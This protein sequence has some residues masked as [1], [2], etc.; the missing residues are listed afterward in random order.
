LST[1]FEIAR[2]QLEG[3]GDIAPGLLPRDI[4]NSWRRSLQAGLDPLGPPVDA[5]VSPSELRERRQRSERITRFARPELELLY[6]QI[7]GAN[8]MVAFAD[9]DGV[10]LDTISDSD[11]QSTSTGRTIV[12]GSV[13]K[14]DLRGTN[15]LGLCLA[16]RAPAKVI[17]QEH[18]FSEHGRVSCLAAPIFDSRNRIVGLIDASSDITARQHHTLALVKLAATN[19]ENRLFLE[20]HRNSITLVF[21]PREEYLTTMSVGMLAFDLDGNL[22]GS[23]SQAISMLNGISLG[24]NCLFQDIFRNSFSDIIDRLFRGRVVQL[25][26]WLGSTVF[27]AASFSSQSDVV[28][29]ERRRSLGISLGNG[30][31]RAVAAE[32]PKR[33]GLVM[34]DPLLR[35]QIT[36]ACNAAKVGLP[37]VIEGKS[38][39]GKKAAAHEIHIRTHPEAPLFSVD[40]AAIS[41]SYFESLLSLSPRAQ[42]TPDDRQISQEFFQDF[43]TL[44]GTLHF[45]EIVELPRD[46]QKLLVRFLDMLGEGSPDSNRAGTK[47]VLFSSGQSIEAAVSAGTLNRDIVRRISGYRFELPK[48]EDRSDFTK[49][50]QTLLAGI[51]PDHVL[52]KAAIDQLRKRT[53]PGNIRD[54]KRALQLM[55]ANARHPVLRKDDLLCLQTIPGDNILPCPKCAGKALREERCRKI[56]RLLQESGGN[57]SLVARQ[58]GISR[59]TVYAHLEPS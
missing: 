9:A 42:E 34:E 43:M 35:R 20:E 59:T 10:L 7:A 37:V 5:A 4:E 29:R 28:A 45:D 52:S 36:L 41:S 13:W 50:C 17:G 49:I 31:G 38:G 12:P 3:H 55:V 25:E 57:I 23:N 15:A 27:A 24:S 32:S 33:H 21:H 46:V 6:S 44:G 30:S 39:T 56:R 14:E 2:R 54:L 8:F 51:S 40:C 18:F 26:D 58:L 11:F 1:G 53:W 19:I 16:T 47:I 22:R 48:L